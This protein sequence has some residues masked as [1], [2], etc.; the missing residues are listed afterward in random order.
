MD[1]VLLKEQIIGDTKDFIPQNGVV[2]LV[3]LVGLNSVGTP[4]LS[5]KMRGAIDE[6]RVWKRVLSSDEFSFFRNFPKG[7][8][9]SQF[10]TPDR[11]L[12][13]SIS[14]DKLAANAIDVLF[15][16]IHGRAL[17]GTPVDVENT[18]EG[19]RTHIDNDE[20]RLQR[21][22]DS[23]WVDHGR[24]WQT[25]E[26][27]YA[28]FNGDL[29]E[30]DERGDTVEFLANVAIEPNRVIVTRGTGRAIQTPRKISMQ[31]LIDGDWVER[32]AL[33]RNHL[34]FYDTNGLQVTSIGQNF[35]VGDSLGFDDGYVITKK[36]DQNVLDSM[37]I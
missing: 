11:I 28:I 22:K 3:V 24:I 29:Q 37:E 2:G 6:V 16:N 17:F 9:N 32:A 5:F 20:V 12:E 26:G 4:F 23:Q 33:T 15:A 25:Q 1:G 21:I 30:E 10:I 18:E 14:A 13:G 36:P 8:G 7:A 19:F 35:N 27:A 34:V 31:Q